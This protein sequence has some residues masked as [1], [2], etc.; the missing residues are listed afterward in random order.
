VIDLDI[1]ALQVAASLVLCTFLSAP[2]MYIAAR[3][4]LIPSVSNQ[5][6]DD[7]ISDAQQDVGIASIIG[8]VC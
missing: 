1:Y 2:I 4:V 7:I 3:M 6:Y 8:V 5:Q